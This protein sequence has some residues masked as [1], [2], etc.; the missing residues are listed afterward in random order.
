MHV[1]SRGSRGDHHPAWRG[2]DF[3]RRIQSVVLAATVLFC[4]AAWSGSTDPQAAQALVSSTADRLL[5][6]LKAEGNSLLNNPARVRDIARQ[7]L[8]PHIDFDTMSRLAVGKDWRTATPAQKERFV[9]EFRQFLLR[10]Y[11]GALIEYTKGNKIP[12]GL[13]RFLPLRASDDVKRV[14]V[15]SEVVQPSGGPPIPVNYQM[16]LNNNA[17]KVVDVQVDGVSM[18]ANY[19]SSFSTELR[20]GG[21]EGLIKTLERRNRELAKG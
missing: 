14:T 4:Q 15:R 11:T 3:L 7:N 12:D 19:R 18:V 6:M 13:M 21:M 20:K 5:G 1:S 16:H 2:T 10:F 17:W 9:A 8:F